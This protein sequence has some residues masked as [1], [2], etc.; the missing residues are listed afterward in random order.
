MYGEFFV[1]ELQ[2]K[3]WWISKNTMQ[4]EEFKACPT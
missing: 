3:S 4:K 2:W 1:D